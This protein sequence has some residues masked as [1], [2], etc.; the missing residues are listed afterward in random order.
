[1][2]NEHQTL[3]LFDKMLFERATLCPPFKKHVPM[4]NEACFLYVLDGGYHSYSEEGT[5]TVNHKEGILMKCGNYLGRFFSSSESKQYKAIAVHF[6]PEVL[7]KIY[8]AEIPA[9]LK[10]PQKPKVGMT[11]VKTDELL[12]RYIEGILFYFENPQLASEELLILK[13]KELILIL[14][15]T[16]NAP[17]VQLILSNLFT[18]STYSFK[19][20]VETHVYTNITISELAQLANLSESSFKREFKKV[21]NDSPANYLRTQKLLKA[22]ELLILSDL[23]ITQIT[24]ECGFNDVAHFSK[25]FKNKFAMTPSAFRLTQINKSLT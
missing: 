4:P 9:F 10:N 6:Y 20:I 25:L 16:Q 8:A 3:D 18:P 14:N 21:Y 5:L 13:L 11:K 2:M 15:E 17:E 24:F 12:Q 19:E 22:E 7:K 23:N 1:M